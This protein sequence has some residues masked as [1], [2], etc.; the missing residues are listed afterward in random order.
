MGGLT[1][2]M[3]SS[4]QKKQYLRQGYFPRQ[5]QQPISICS[6]LGLEVRMVLGLY[7]FLKFLNLI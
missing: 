2:E 7:R 6:F 3:I 4:F 5:A 1:E